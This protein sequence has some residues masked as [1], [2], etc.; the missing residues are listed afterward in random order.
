M[1]QPGAAV[2]EVFRREHGL[3]LAS[4]IR[5]FGDFDL[6][7]EALADAVFAAVESW[8]EVGVPVSPAAWL[9][10]V[11][12]RKAVD[13]LRRQKS[14]AVKLES[15]GG[16][17]AVADEDDDGGF[18]D[19]RL[20]LMFA[21]C[22]PALSPEARVALTLRSLGGLTTAEIARAFLTSEST[23]YQRIT[24][25][26]NKIRVAGIPIE[27]PSSA[28]LPQRLDSVLAVIYLVFNEGYS[29]ITGE[30]L[31]RVDLCAEAIRLAEMMAALLPDEP[32]ARGLAALCMLTDARRPA[33]VDASGRL[34]LLEEQDRSLWERSKIQRGLEHLEAARSLGGAAA[35]VL[36]AEIAAVH[37]SAGTWEDSDWDRIVGLYQHLFVL[38]QSPVVALNHAAA[39]AMRDGP[40]AGLDLMAQLSDPLDGYQPFHASRAELLLRAGRAAEAAEGFRRA[41]DFPVNDIDRRHLESRHRLAST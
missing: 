4:L 2:E 22:H 25:A 14:L 30:K 12:K 1:N 6:A 31:V 8:P 32:E 26:R 38:K 7:E 10:T 21:C 23:M 40:E 15:I 27:L 34:V 13:R 11:A 37:T 35:Y 41:L 24:R 17:V 3:V 20:R 19:E 16:G 29:T 39:V 28:D 36:Q 33:R 9:H 5:T 18:P